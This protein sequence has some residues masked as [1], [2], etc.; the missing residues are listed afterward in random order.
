[1]E[2]LTIT[3]ASVKSKNKTLFKNLNLHIKEG[4][5]WAVVGPSGSGKTALL[6]TIRGD[7]FVSDGQIL[8]HYY[9]LYKTN[10]NVSDPL[11]SHR[12]LI[13]YVDVKHDFTNLSHTRDFFYQQ[14]FNAGYANESQ[15]VDGYLRDISSKETHAGP[16]NFERVICDFDLEPLQDKHLIKLSNGETKRL[17]IA[18]ALLK[19]PVL[20]ILNEPCQ[21]FDNSQ[22]KYF[23][24]LIDSIAGQNEM[25]MIY[26][27]H[28]REELPECIEKELRLWENK[29]FC[30]S[31]KQPYQK[32]KNKCQFVHCMQIFGGLFLIIVKVCFRFLLESCNY[33]FLKWMNE[34]TVLLYS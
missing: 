7:F 34:E 22:Q 27:T 9:N 12:N 17:R 6:K 14:R 29:S 25:A 13:S 24:A 1:M 23:K 26:V 5:N 10:H 20:L 30:K 15:T 31:S 28:H 18:A 21:G 16:W 4:Q 3:N 33:K 2:V 19:N 11:F 8:H 32:V